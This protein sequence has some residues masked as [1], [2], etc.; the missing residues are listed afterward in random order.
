MEWAESPEA[1]QAHISQVRKVSGFDEAESGS[2]STRGFDSLEATLA[3]CVLRP[4]PA[5]CTARYSNLTQDADQ[6]LVLG[7]AVFPIDSTNSPGFSNTKTSSTNQTGEKGIGF[8]SVFGIADVVSVAS[9]HYSFQFDARR[10]LDM[11]IPQW[12][13]FPASSRPGFTSTLLQIRDRHATEELFEGLKSTSAERNLFL[14]RLRWTTL[15]LTWKTERH[16]ERASAV[17]TRR[18]RMDPSAS[19]K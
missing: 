12:V 16:G 19:P 8:K 6:G 11:I 1:A 10:R 5:H 13:D 4:L 17:S 3:M 15:A 9:G 7:A 18:P 2:P 14:R